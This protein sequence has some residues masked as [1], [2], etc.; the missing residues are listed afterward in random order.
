MILYE[1]TLRIRK[2]YI[3]PMDVSFLISLHT[4][5]YPNEKLM[6][7]ERNKMTLK[8]K[9]IISVCIAVSTAIVFSV[10]AV[11]SKKAAA[12]PPAQ[13]ETVSL[14]RQNLQ[15][16]IS[17]TGNLESVGKRTIVSELTEQK[18]VKLNVKVGDRVKE[19]DEIAALDPT[20]IEDKLKILRESVAFAEQKAEI[21]K[22]I[23][24]RNLDST[25]QG[26]EIEKTR[27]QQAAEAANNALEKAKQESDHAKSLY[28]QEK[29]KIKDKEAT[30][31]Q[32]RGESEAV[33][34]SMEE[35]AALLEDIKRQREEK[36]TAKSRLEEGRTQKETALKEAQTAYEAAL[37][38]F[39]NMAKD[40]TQTAENIE[41][42]RGE[43]ENKKTLMQNAEKEAADI[44]SQ[45]AA[46][47]AELQNLQES[48][49]NAQEAYAGAESE[50]QLKSTA[51]AETENAY[52]AAKDMAEAKESAYKQSDA[53]IMAA[54]TDYQKSVQSVEDINRNS[55]K[56]I[57]DLQDSLKGVELTKAGSNLQ[58]KMD[59]KKYEHQ[60]SDCVIKASA[61]G[62]ITSV[63]IQEGNV[64]KGGEIATIQDAEHL[65]AVALV[66]QFDITK[67]QNGM[68]AQIQT[69]SSDEMKIN[70]KISFISP[71]PKSQPTTG[72][73]ND[74]SSSTVEYPV[75][76]AF[77]SSGKQLRLGMKV[78]INIVLEEVKNAYAVPYNCITTDE[79]GNPA[80]TVLENETEK[81][82]EVEQG[83]ETD[84]FVEIKSTK[85]REGMQ[86]IVPAAE[87][88]AE[89]DNIKEAGL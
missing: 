28:E 48:E 21:D 61:D 8:R 45:I 24:A 83:L 73:A 37:S 16:I 4:R 64:Y 87:G 66:D 62:I 46:V 58:E 9:I 32:L 85:L 15:N 12:Q 25:V 82:I 74:T 72:A 77:N 51:A 44:G 20:P 27:A 76:I 70:G 59:I 55:G 63:G 26:S 17:I 52:A 3:Q 14:D 39:E 2:G 71:I 29:Y 40:E 88:E 41:A 69:A 68:K 42:A 84:Y 33:K 75:E 10:I 54:G 89:S 5:N 50:Y 36:Q 80:I 23:A 6:R 22:N 43:M 35:Q 60:L 47:D 31:N 81:T 57:A 79:Q 11:N 1:E 18:I 49:K 13:P 19:G 30:L 86:V 65:V 78:K 38:I 67:L 56:S 53:A 7:Q 34:K